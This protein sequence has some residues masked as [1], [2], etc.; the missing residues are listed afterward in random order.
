M[1]IVLKYVLLFSI[2]RVVMQI[3]KRFLYVLF[4]GAQALWCAASW[5][6]LVQRA[7]DQ[8]EGTASLCNKRL[9]AQLKIDGKKEE[10]SVFPVID[11]QRECL[12]L[13]E[14]Y[15]TRMKVVIKD[16]SPE[17]YADYS[18]QLQRV[19]MVQSRLNL[20]TQ[21]VKNH[22]EGHDTTREDVDSAMER[23]ASV[24]NENAANLKVTESV[25]VRRMRRLIERTKTIIMDNSC[26]ECNKDSN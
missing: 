3:L 4:L 10:R 1:M 14:C 23:L 2:K 7:E 17:V 19:Q 12:S 18:L 13:L 25:L 9:F 24:E 22:Q 11:G 21:L 6:A 8:C 20:M 16:G 26:F 15:L 5:E